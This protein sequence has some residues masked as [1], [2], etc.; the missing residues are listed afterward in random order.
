MTKRVQIIRAGRFDQVPPYCFMQ[1]GLSPEEG[2]LAAAK[3]LKLTHPIDLLNVL[4]ILRRAAVATA[5]QKTKQPIHY[6][7]KEE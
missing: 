5:G 1:A 6:P 4:L 2:A 3:D 7:F